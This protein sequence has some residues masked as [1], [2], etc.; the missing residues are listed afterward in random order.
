MI[1]ANPFSYARP[2]LCAA[3]A[4]EL[5]PFLAPEWSRNA[6]VTGVGAVETLGVLLPA[7]SRIAP[8]A[9][10]EGRGPSPAS[11]ALS[12]DAS[13]FSHGRPD[14]LVSIGIAGAYRETGLAPGD[15]VLGDWEA[16]GDIGMQTAEGGFLP[17]GETPFSGPF[18]GRRLPLH[19][20]V[21]LSS[22]SHFPGFTVRRGGGLTVNRCTGTEALG[23]ERRNR[24]EA[25]FESME[26]S[27]VAQAGLLFDLPVFEIRAISNFAAAR[28]M[29]PDLIALALRH[30]FLY[31]E[32]LQQAAALAS[33][34]EG[35]SGRA[36]TENP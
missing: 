30:L 4:P 32:A 10:L 3:T 25:D 31:L 2:L 14:C 23:Q 22:S 29:K 8:A 9:P 12:R 5:G 26:G 21:D 19:S 13:P 24:F 17:L 1:A 16:Y 20:V 27:A 36:G 34:E 35:E 18:T 28:D 15:I 11:P 7:L 33:P 6:I